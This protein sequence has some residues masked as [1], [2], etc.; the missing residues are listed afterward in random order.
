MDNLSLGISTSS[1]EGKGKNALKTMGYP[2]SLKGR[3]DAPDRPRP[4]AASATW[5][6]RSGVQTQANCVW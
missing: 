4:V 3:N 6:S 2:A 5:S 1:L